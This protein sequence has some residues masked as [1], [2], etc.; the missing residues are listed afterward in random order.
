[1]SPEELHS[2]SHQLHNQTKHI[3]RKIVKEIRK[4]R[5]TIPGEL[6]EWL[7][8]YLAE[9][10]VPWWELFASRIYTTKRTKIESGIERPDRVLLALSEEEPGVIPMPGAVEDATWRI[11]FLE[12]VSGSMGKQS[13]EIGR[14]ELQHILNM[15]DEMEVRWVQFDAAATFDQVYRHG[16]TLPAEAHGRGG[17]DFDEAFKY[18]WKYLGNGET[19]PDAVVVYTDG[20]APA[21]KPEF[22][23][24][25][26]IPVI[27]CVTSDGAGEHLAQAGYGEVIVCDADQNRMW[28]HQKEGSV[29]ALADA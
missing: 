13:I 1:M 28:Q 7:D 4:G 17:T 3:L 29:D 9:P 20:G 5:G 8:E 22:Q 24:P 11:L 14:S 10:I 19:E 6:I 2:L 25:P 15:D 12:D 18:I 16:D 27:W 26:E 21:V 23:L